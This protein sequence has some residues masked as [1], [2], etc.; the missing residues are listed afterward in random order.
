MRPGVRPQGARTEDKL[1][2]PGDHPFAGHR[3][4]QGWRLSPA[5]QSWRR[6]GCRAIN[7]NAAPG[8]DDQGRPR[9]GLGRS[10][11]S[12]DPACQLD[13]AG[14]PLRHHMVSGR[15]SQVSPAIDRGARRILLSSA[16]C[17]RFAVILSGRHR[18]GSG[19]SQHRHARRAGDR[20]AWDSGVR[21]H[22]R[23]PADLPF[24]TRHQPDRR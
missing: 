13:G 3:S 2:A 18:Q 15:D 17:A 8:T 19:S 24:L 10:Y 12:D 22:S 11:R 21:N 23:N 5:R 4:A 16:V 20:V 7:E 14:A 1:G 9:C 6:Q